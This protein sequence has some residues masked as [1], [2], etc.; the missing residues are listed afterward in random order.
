MLVP[1]CIFASYKAVYIYQNFTCNFF[2]GYFLSNHTIEMV[3]IGFFLQHTQF[4]EFL[5][6][7]IVVSSA[8]ILFVYY[9]WQIKIW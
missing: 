3:K 6:A 1:F 7:E 8:V 5:F 2:G 9:I 4:I